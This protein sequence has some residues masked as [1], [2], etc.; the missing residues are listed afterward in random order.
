M[1]KFLTTLETSAKIEKIIRQAKEELTLITPYL[2]LTQIFYDRLIE[3]NDRNVKIKLIYGKE[4]LNSKDLELL[5]GL[6]NLE[7]YFCENLHAKCYLNENLMVIT[8][9]NLHEFSQANNR[10]MGV[11]IKLEEDTEL[12][13]N[14]KKEA[15]YIIK[16]SIKEN[17]DSK[18][19]NLEQINSKTP[20]K[21]FCIRCHNYIEFNIQK[22]LCKNCFDVWLKFADP[23]YQESYCHKCG[24]KY[25]TSFSHPLCIDCWHDVNR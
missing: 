25:D 9:M 7:L 10:E 12:F 17:S 3:A 2:K 14:A 19:S 18:I 8:S 15:S 22:P 1:A 21:G 20:E 24:K 16:A 4:E 5:K 23:H 11:Q 6:D 13:N